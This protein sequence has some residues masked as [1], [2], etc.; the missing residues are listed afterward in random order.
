[1][2]ASLKHLD[3]DGATQIT[4]ENWPDAVAGAIQTAKKF[5]VENNGDRVLG[6]SPLA[7]VATIT[8]V[9][10][11]DGSTFL[12]QAL[13]TVTCSK[14]WGAGTNGSPTATL[15]SA[16]AGGV[17]GTTGIRGY[18]L[19][20]TNANGE[21]IASAEVTINVD[22]VTKKVTVSWVQV[23]NATGY[24]LYRTNTPG[25]Y[26]TPSLRTTIGSGATISFIDDGS[27]VSTGAPPTTNTTGGWNL[28]LALGAPAGGG[29]WAGTGLKYYKVV[30]YDANGGIISVSQE[31]SVNVDDITKKVTV[32]WTAVTGATSYK[33]YR[34]TVQGTYIAALRVTQAGV[35]FIDDG[36][37]TGVG[38]LTLASSFGIPPTL[39]TAGMSFGTLAIGQQAFYW[40]NRVIPAATSEVGNPRTALITFAEG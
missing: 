3:S 12:R 28:S 24:K 38:D 6:S 21:T 31:N 34:S 20:A 17:W 14:P 26:T 23:P 37:A 2:A 1:M 39:G 22:D 5:G 32:S 8:P 33:I 27:A 7:L 9:G 11:N 4:A 19:T 18:V 13:D 15:G 10:S 35:S 30:A 36:T 25:T 29:V 16:G 40:E